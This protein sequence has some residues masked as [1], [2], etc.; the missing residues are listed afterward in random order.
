M[1]FLVTITIGHTSA[2]PQALQTAMTK[3]VDDETA[4]GTMVLSGGL[5]PSSQGRL[6]TLSKGELTVRE[7]AN[8]HVLID[9][10]AV[11]EAASMEEAIEKAKPLL[12]LHQEYMEHWEGECT[13]RP[14]VTH[15]L[16]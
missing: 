3:L 13:V 15:C 14:I 7:S 11:L 2:P 6:L 10:F 8:G 5:A 16:P 4:A 9:G 1:Q 12:Q